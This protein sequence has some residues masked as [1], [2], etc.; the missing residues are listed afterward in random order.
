[1]FLHILILLSGINLLQRARII[2]I[3][4]LSFIL[5]YFF[6]FFSSFAQ[7]SHSMPIFCYQAT[8][9]IIHFILHLKI[10]LLFAKREEFLE[11]FLF[12]ILATVFQSF[13]FNCKLDHTGNRSYQLLPKYLNFEGAIMTSYFCASDSFLSFNYITCP[14]IVYIAYPVPCAEFLLASFLHI[15][16]IHIPNGSRFLFS[17]LL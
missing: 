17:F 11:L 14:H 9:H 16:H 8:I 5:S 15:E 12:C 2:D 7:P 6:H 1:M 13:N 10:E 4:I 3:K